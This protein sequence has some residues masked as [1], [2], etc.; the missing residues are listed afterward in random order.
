MYTLSVVY[1]DLNYV[2]SYILKSAPCT[3]NILWILHHLFI[4]IKLQMMNYKQIDI[5]L[6]SNKRQTE[7]GN[8]NKTMY[9]ICVRTF[10]FD[11]KTDD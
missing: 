8:R 1:F 2:Y 7:I 3:R 6:H 10:S 9:A 11:V 5:I 4:I